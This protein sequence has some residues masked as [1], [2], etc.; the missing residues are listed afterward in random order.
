M[1]PPVPAPRT[2]RRFTGPPGARRVSKAR[3]STSAAARA[4]GIPTGPSGGPVSPRPLADVADALGLA[5]D[6]LVPHGHDKAKITA[7]ATPPP[8][9]RQILVSAIT[10]TP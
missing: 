8:T 4:S 6:R 9:G 2:S 5:H 1:L 3:A 10:P 7:A